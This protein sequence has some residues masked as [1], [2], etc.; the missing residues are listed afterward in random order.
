MAKKLLASYK[1]LAGFTFSR[2]EKARPVLKSF[3]QKAKTSTGFTLIELLIVIAI[4]VIVIAVGATSYTTVNRNARNA[5]RAADL[6]K[7]AAALEEFYADHGF[8]PSTRSSTNPNGSWEAA[9]R[10]VDGDH[11][12]CLLGGTYNTS[13]TK[14]SGWYDWCGMNPA[15]DSSGGLPTPPW[16]TSNLP[17]NTYIVNGEF[18]KF[19]RDPVNHGDAAIDL[20]PYAYVSN[21]QTYAIATRYYEGLA[22]TENRLVSGNEYWT[23]GSPWDSELKNCASGAGVP[24]NYVVRSPNHR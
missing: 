12:N 19:P 10:T 21:G 17:A 16:L 24:C 9:S 18:D 13:F 14:T 8:Y 3:L 23:S 1:P 22:P 4:I 5:Q 15:N 7:I 6:N 11:T 2:S 20:R